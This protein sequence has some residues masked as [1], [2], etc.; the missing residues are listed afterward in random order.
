MLDLVDLSA[1]AW[2]SRGTN[3]LAQLGFAEDVQRI[4][5][6]FKNAEKRTIEL[7]PRT[8]PAVNFGRAAVT[9][10]GETWVFAISPSLRRDVIAYLSVPAPA[11]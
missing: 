4:T 6:E 8:L 10:D 1:A 7:S 9:L 5:L 11:L 2:L 3:N